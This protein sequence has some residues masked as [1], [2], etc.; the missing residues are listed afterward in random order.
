MWNPMATDEFLIKSKEN[1]GLFDNY[2]IEA[3]KDYYNGI[4]QRINQGELRDGQ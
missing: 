1:K 2:F 3:R 4:T